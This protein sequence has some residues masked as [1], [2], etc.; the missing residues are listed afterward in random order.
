VSSAQ[1]HAGRL[2]RLKCFPP[3]RCTQTPPVAGPQTRKAE[4]WHRCRKII[5]A[6][7]GK[8][9]KRGGHDGADS[10]TPGV[11]SAG[12]A[13][14]VSKKSRHGVQRADFEPVTEDIACCV[15]PAAS[16]PAIIPQHCSLPCRCPRTP[17]RVDRVS[18]R[19]PTERSALLCTLTLDHRKNLAFRAAVYNRDEEISSS[20]VAFIAAAI[21]RVPRLAYLIEPL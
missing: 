13:A 21:P 18:G 1:D 7:S 17:P 16:I 2:A 9:E 10:V 19:D 8:F 4:F 3:T 11:V 15:R 20:S 14:A 5:T 6:G 12:I